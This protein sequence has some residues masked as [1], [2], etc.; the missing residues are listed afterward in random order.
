VEV[1]IVRTGDVTSSLDVDY[2]TANGTAK[3]GQDFEAQSG[4]LHFAPLETS[5]TVFVPL[6]YNPLVSQKKT[7]SVTL[8]NPSGGVI[9]GGGAPSQT[10]TVH[11]V[12]R[13]GSLDF[14]FE[15][16]FP[17]R[18]FPYGGLF[19]ATA[20]QDNG[21]ILVSRK[22][23]LPSPNSDTGTS[24][25]RLNADGTIDQSFQLEVPYQAGW[26]GNTISGVFVF[27]EQPDGKI[28]L[29]GPSQLKVNGESR[30]G[31]A[32][33][34]SDGT[35]DESFSVDVPI[36]Q[37]GVRS[38]QV[39]PDGKIM[40]GGDFSL[41]LDDSK[42]LNSLMRLEPDGRLDRTFRP[43][44][45]SPDDNNGGVQVNQVVLQ[46]DGKILVAGS[47]N[48]GLDPPWNP[49]T[50]LDPDG[51]VDP[52]F[53]PVIPTDNN[54]NPGTLF[55]LVLQP[56][57]KI[58]CAGS[59]TMIDVDAFPGVIR[60]LPSGGVDWDFR[61]DVQMGDTSSMVMAL[62]DDGRVVLAG[63][64]LYIQGPKN[65]YRQGIARLNQNGTLDAS[66]DSGMGPTDNNSG[67][68]GATMLLLLEDNQ[69]LVGG[70]FDQFDG[71]SRNGMALLNNDPA[72]LIT[73]LSHVPS[74]PLQFNVRSLPGR[75]YVVERSYDL[76]SWSAV[77][78]NSPTL[79]SYSYS[80]SPADARGYYRVRRVSP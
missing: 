76:S 75:T 5:K 77:R 11:D 19:L 48:P 6:A 49:L 12:D 39:Q 67:N 16:P 66:F 62:Q 55:S 15:S 65:I 33:V 18:S 54:G 53:A 9:L 34:E 14:S 42:R 22:E 37:G 8:K 72:V 31:I 58:I 43:A 27:K 64:N 41:P 56:D 44:G 38:I 23:N 10:V 50:R 4:S 24:A 30:P 32:R 25:F 35:L 29:G 46:S 40:A 79:Y 71:I 1:K 57:G 7:F 68:T 61:S 52:S 20:L 17:V 21:K 69:L 2:N 3:A 73:S 28:L 36:D 47:A 13:P 59:F 80:E 70:S 26:W 45:L 60:L 63:P 78:T 74:G 51:S